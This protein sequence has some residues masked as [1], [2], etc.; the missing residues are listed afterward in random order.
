M[1]NGAALSELPPRDATAL[2][3]SVRER[4]KAAITFGEL[5]AGTRLNQV[6][7][8]KQ[9]GVSRMPVRAAVSDLQAE[10]LLD[11]LPSGGA[12]VRELTETD[13]R[14]VYEVRIA[15]ETQAALLAAERHSAT[16]LDDMKAVLRD[17]RLL[18]GS[19][20]PVALLALDRRF[21]MALLDATGN[22]NFRRTIIPIWATVE[23]AMVRMLV[24]IPVMFESAWAEHASIAEAL[25]SGD[26]QL[27]EDCVRTHLESSVERLARTMRSP[28]PDA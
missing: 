17:H 23:R 13:M 11:P 3:R 20:D 12:V 27:A 15:L 5:A 24:S 10:G 28:D 21:H 25:A 9:L 22:P 1:S 2:V 19:S 7:V 8:A 16:H 4:L 6:Q 26:S 14:H 18:G